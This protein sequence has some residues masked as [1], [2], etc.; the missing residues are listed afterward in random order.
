[1]RS[2]SPRARP[3]R[4]ASRAPIAIAVGAAT[5]GNGSAITITGGNGAGGTAS[6]GDINLVPGTAV[7]TGTPGELKVNSAAGLMEVCWFQPLS[8]T[9]CPASAAVVTFFMANRAYRVKAIRV[10]ESTVGTS[11]AFTFHKNPSGTAAGAGTALLTGAVTLGGTT[12]NTPVAGTMSSTI[13]TVTLAAGDSLSFTVS[14][15]VGSA[16]GLQ[17]SALLVPV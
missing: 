16:A 10:R 2:A 9:A 3:G 5:A 14:G 15:T 8:T 4:A 7:S 13:A 17:V 1:V 6:G 12:N 11:E